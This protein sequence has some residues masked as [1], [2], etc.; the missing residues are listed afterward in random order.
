[1]WEGGGGGVAKRGG[2]KERRLL[3]AS[4]LLLSPTR[5]SG[6]APPPLLLGWDTSAGGTE[7][8]VPTGL[9]TPAENGLKGS[10]YVRKSLTVP[11]HSS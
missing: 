7:K 11:F 9:M 4:L 2:R 8:K 5:K 10:R 6:T 1:M 3:L